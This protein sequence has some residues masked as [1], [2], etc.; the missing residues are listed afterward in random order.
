MSPASSCR[1]KSVT[2]RRS[3]QMGC[4][5]LALIGQFI[6]IP[7]DCVFTVETS[8]R[9]GM[10]AAY[11]LLQL[12]KPVPPVHQS[13]YDLRAI[14]GGLRQMTDRQSFSAA[15][16]PPELLEMLQAEL[17]IPML[18]GVPGYPWDGVTPSLS[19]EPA[20]DPKAR[21]RHTRR[22]GCVFADAAPLSTTA[23]AL[24]QCHSG[25]SFSA[26]PI[27]DW[28]PRGQLHAPPSRYRRM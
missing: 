2:D 5:N 11:G 4:T 24:P 25:A 8:V 13:K 21:R 17:A 19:E 20:P 10:M 23:G 26:R 18:N 12:D 27:R 16:F 6:E 1:E 9:T 14:V 15:D 22:F 7:D 28:L 3:F